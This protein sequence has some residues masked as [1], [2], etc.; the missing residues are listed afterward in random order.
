MT[1][2][3]P[4][5][6]RGVMV[7]MIDTSRRMLR[8]H[9]KRM[10]DP[11]SDGNVTSIKF[12]TKRELRAYAGVYNIT[13]A[14]LV[15]SADI[16]RSKTESRNHNAK[17]GRGGGW[18]GDIIYDVVTDSEKEFPESPPFTEVARSVFDQIA[19]ALRANK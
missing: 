1:V 10:G 18:L 15:W 2:S 5:W 13:T 19:L 16:S 4:L 3:P 11:G 6:V 7:S 14:A 9:R 12:K 17:S 8:T